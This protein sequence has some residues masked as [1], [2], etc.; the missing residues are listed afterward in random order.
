MIGF[1]SGF[2]GLR[3]GRIPV[4]VIRSRGC[5][6]VRASAEEGPPSALT[7]G[8]IGASAAAIPV[9]GWSE[10]ILATTGS[11]LPDQY[12]ALEGISYLVVVGVAIW[13]V[14]TKVRKKRHYEVV[15]RDWKGAEVL[16]YSGERMRLIDQGKEVVV[17]AVFQ[18]PD[19][20][21]TSEVSILRGDILTEHFYSDRWYNVFRITS[22]ID[23][24]LRGWYCNITRPAQIGPDSVSADDLALDLVVSPTG[25]ITILDEDEFEE[26]PLDPGDRT[27]ALQAVHQLQQLVRLRSYPFADIS[28]P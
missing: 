6:R 10:Y 13:S 16:R 18:P 24:T 15:K 21:L 23:R 7:Y 11:G 22:P 8:V 25:S 12:G 4:R 27:S 3:I 2:S 1:V 26:L 14:V 17:D 28:F 9:M 20:Y 19:T 5:A